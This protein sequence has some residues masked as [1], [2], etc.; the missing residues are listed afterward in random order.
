MNHCVKD[1]DQLEH[2]LQ[3]EYCFGIKRL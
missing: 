1:V 2:W 3:H